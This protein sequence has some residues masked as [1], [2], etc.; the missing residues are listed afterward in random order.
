M[1]QRENSIGLAI[2]V[3]SSLIRVRIDLLKPDLIMWSSTFIQD[4]FYTELVFWLGNKRH[5]IFL[6]RT[7]QYRT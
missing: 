3:H 7:I 1:Q 5:L 2:K 6:T 4:I